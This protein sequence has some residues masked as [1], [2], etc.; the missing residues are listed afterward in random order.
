M[1]LALKTDGPTFEMRLLHQSTGGH[2]SIFSWDDKRTL[3]DHL[4]G[5]IIDIMSEHENRLSD[6]TG[7][8]IFSGPGSFTSLR[9]GHSVAN[10]L[11]DSLG[12]AV[13]GTSGDQW[14]QRGIEAL[15]TLSPGRPALPEYGAEAHI[16][17][18]KA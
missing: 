13:I 5:R 11:A 14:V 6:L 4:L 18:P 15:N 10:A 17:K 7:I 16:T 2:D 8:I 9:I 1:I 3:A 12:I